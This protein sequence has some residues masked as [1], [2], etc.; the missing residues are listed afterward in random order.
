MEY[1]VCEFPLLLLLSPTRSHAHAEHSETAPEV[2]IIQAWPPCNPVLQ[3]R[4]DDIKRLPLP[5]ELA[6][7]C[8]EFDRTG[9]EEEEPCLAILSTEPASHPR[10]GSHFAQLT[11]LF[12]CFVL[13]SFLVQSACLRKLFF[14]FFDRLSEW[15]CPYA[16]FFNLA[17]SFWCVNWTTGRFRY[18]NGSWPISFLPIFKIISLITIGII[19]S[20][21]LL[22]K[23][24]LGVC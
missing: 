1:S 8:W 20:V 3:L 7:F 23:A 14:F 2:L 10:L 18:E 4:W 21:H 13:F 6:L 11:C 16:L 5:F 22:S 17:T 19:S 24:I 9:E 12:F 15:C